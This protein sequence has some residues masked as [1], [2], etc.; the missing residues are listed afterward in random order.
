VSLDDEHF[1]D[2][3]E[4]QPLA[5]ADDEEPPSVETLNPVE[6]L[7]AAETD[8]HLPGVDDAAFPGPN[9]ILEIP[10]VDESEIPA[11][12]TVETA[13]PDAT[14]APPVFDTEAVAPAPVAQPAATNEARRSTRIR[15]QPTASVPSMSGSRYSYAVTQLAEQGVLNP[16][17]HM[18]VQEDFYQA[19]P[20]VVAAIMMSSR[21]SEDCR[22]GARKPI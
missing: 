15:T 4:P 2:D 12:D 1:A 5:A 3:E 21:S 11:P 17:A 20:D 13:A 10:G 18:F 16:D 8:A 14:A 19:D 7:P 22:S 9:D 6:A